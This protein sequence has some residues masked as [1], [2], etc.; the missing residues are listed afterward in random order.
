M[1]FY[2][3]ILLL[4]ALL[5]SAQAIAMERPLSRTGEQEPTLILELAK[6]VQGKN[7][8]R[9]FEL[10][11]KESQETQKYLCKNAYLDSK[12]LSGK[13]AI[14]FAAE[15]SNTEALR[16]LLDIAGNT[17]NAWDFYHMTPLF[18]AAK[19]GNHATLQ[20]LLEKGADD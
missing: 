3:K 2:N 1:N 18:Y 15:Q 5:V 20:L 19:K 6:A 16:K 10:L 11:S 14:H 17:I 12:H 4:S 9:F 8:D 13:L 7:F